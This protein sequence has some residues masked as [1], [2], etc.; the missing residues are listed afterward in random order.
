MK[1]VTRGC[2]DDADCRISAERCKRKGY[3]HYRCHVTCCEEDYCN[4][5]HLLGKQLCDSVVL[6]GAVFL[7]L[8]ARFNWAC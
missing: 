7:S 5:G 3:Y 1:E 8:T 2:G 6:L 4:K